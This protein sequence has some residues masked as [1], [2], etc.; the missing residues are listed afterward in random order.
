[1]KIIIPVI[2][3]DQNKNSIAQGFHKTDFVCI[4]DSVENSYHWHKKSD[5][6]KKDGNL[7]IQLKIKGIYTI[8][9]NEIEL[10]TL[11]LFTDIGLK[12]YKSDGTNLVENIKL[13]ESNQL[14]PF[15]LKTALG[16]INCDCSGSHNISYN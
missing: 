3:N 6:S 5:I 9:T 16:V 14:K 15:T 12:V 11:S 1:M 7:C 10:M 2:D 13:F 4:Y 8:I